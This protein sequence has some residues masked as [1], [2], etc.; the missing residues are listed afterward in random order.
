MMGK[1]LT[2]SYAECEPEPDK[3]RFHEAKGL[4]PFRRGRAGAC[5]CAR[6][7]TRSEVWSFQISDEK[8]SIAQKTGPA[9][10]V[11]R[12]MSPCGVAGLGKGTT[13]TGVPRLAWRH[14]AQQRGSRRNG[15][16]PYGR[17]EVTGFCLECSF[18]A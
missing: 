12:Q 10:R 15:N 11:A 8:R 9:R 18:G 6:Q 13:I 4:L 2:V 1:S 7:G 3:W 17:A 5:F 14:L 16:R